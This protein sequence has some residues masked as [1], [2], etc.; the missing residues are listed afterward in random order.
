MGKDTPDARQR[1]TFSQSALS[2]ALALFS[3]CK[4]TV[5]QAP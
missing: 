1:V 5:S 4:H 3:D 2:G